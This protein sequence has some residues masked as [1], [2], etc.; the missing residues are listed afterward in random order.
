[1]EDRSSLLK[2]YNDRTTLL[3]KGYISEIDL[4]N[5][6]DEKKIRISQVLLSNLISYSLVSNCIRPELLIESISDQSR[7]IL[8]YKV[9]I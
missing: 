6:L 8:S 3:N 5:Y 4:E 9:F 2:L 7:G 1:M